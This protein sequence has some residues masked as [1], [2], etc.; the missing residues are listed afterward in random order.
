MLHVN[1]KILFILFFASAFIFS[2]VFAQNSEQ[3]THIPYFGY[4]E[5]FQDE[6]L[7]IAFTGAGIAA[8]ALFLFL[9]R[10]SI[11][12]RNK[13]TKSYH[14]D[15]N[16][17]YDKYHSKWNDEGEYF[18]E[19][20]SKKS[21]EKYR[22]QFLNSKLPDYYKILGVSKNATQNEIKS[23]F[24]GLAKEWHPDKAKNE[25]DDK[26]KEFNQAYEVLSDEDKRK[27][28]DKY[29]KRL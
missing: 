12:S 2:S 14:S 5:Y 15:V 11:F 20:R 28:Y 16:R 4:T 29:F 10:E 1:M 17:D 22:E 8:T 19:E 25:T 6:D 23:K 9:F 21:D 13:E 26:M 3:E 27:S 24:R 18:Q 7:I